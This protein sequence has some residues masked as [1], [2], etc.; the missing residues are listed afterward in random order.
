MTKFKLI[1][2]KSDDV[3]DVLDVL[4]EHKQTLDDLRI[5]VEYM[6]DDEI[7][8]LEDVE[9]NSCAFVLDNFEGEVFE[10]LKERNARI[11]SP[12][13]LSQCFS[14]SKPLPK[15]PLIVHSFAFEGTCVSFSGMTKEEKEELAR[16]VEMMCGAVTPNFYQTNDLLIA[17]TLDTTAQKY[18]AAIMWKIPIVRPE[19]VDHMWKCGANAE[20][21]KNAKFLK[22]F[23]VPVF[24]GCVVCTSGLS[25]HER[26]LLGQLVEENGGK[27]SAA[28]EKNVCTHLVLNAPSGE[29]YKFASSF[30]VKPVTPSWL[31]RCIENGIRYHERRYHPDPEIANKKRSVLKE[32]SKTN[33]V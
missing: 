27:Y 3:E 20:S 7:L 15:T 18:L 5:A 19:I 16:K 31:R 21:L 28:M 10:S 23:N 30:G 13:V 11:W 17:E 24:K 2:R 26:T 29:K 6:E 32:T 8:N 12:H 9:G 25:P 14:V 22:E 33:K 4:N 1:A